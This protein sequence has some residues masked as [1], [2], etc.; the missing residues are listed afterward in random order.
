ME[1]DQWDAHSTTDTDAHSLSDYMLVTPEI[2]I[3]NPVEK[4]ESSSS[5][6]SLLM[7]LVLVEQSLV[8]PLGLLVTSSYI[9]TKCLKFGRPPA[10][11][12]IS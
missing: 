10:F 3:V 1:A 8:M 7:T 11:G 12:G 4:T 2:N 6:N 9:I 5:C